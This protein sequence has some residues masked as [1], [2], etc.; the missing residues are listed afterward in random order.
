MI[1]LLGENDYSE[2]D[3]F[4][5]IKEM[6]HWIKMIK[7]FFV[8]DSKAQKSIAD[9]FY[10]DD[11]AHQEDFKELQTTVKTLRKLYKKLNDITEEV[12]EKEY[13]EK[14]EKISESFDESVLNRRTRTNYFSNTLNLIEENNY[15]YDDLADYLEN[16]LD[17]WYGRL[18]ELADAISD[19]GLDPEEVNSE[20]IIVTDWSDDE[21]VSC[22]ITL[23]GTS[24]TISL[25]KFEMI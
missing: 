12:E 17:S 13:K 10:H 6:N 24:R 23:G 16:N 9:Y 11:G 21:P 20:Y 15:E 3:E 5:V 19:L 2:T 8:D 22:K 14:N 4:T 1:K 25:E 7:K 18:N